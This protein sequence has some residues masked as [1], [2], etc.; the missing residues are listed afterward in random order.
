MTYPDLAKFWYEFAGYAAR[1]AHTDQAIEGLRE[2][3]S[4]D[5]MYFVLAAGDHDFELVRPRIT[6]FLDN[7]RDEARKES[8]GWIQELQL[9]LERAKEFDAT[10]EMAEYEERTKELK[11]KVD[12]NNYYLYLEIP[13]VARSLLIAINKLEIKLINREIKLKTEEVASC[14][15][16]KAALDESHRVLKAIKSLAES[17][18]PGRKLILAIIILSQVGGVVVVFL[19]LGALNLWS[20]VLISSILAVGSLLFYLGLRG[21][22]NAKSRIETLNRNYDAKR[23]EAEVLQSLIDKAMHMIPNKLEPALKEASDYLKT[24]L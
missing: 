18:I 4:R 3:I 14:Q 16:Q 5:P 10:H 23:S 21:L 24:K 19:G 6:E 22:K 17:D 7:L 15:K 12:K 1:S 9:C 2:A 20:I 11:D 13:A 8:S